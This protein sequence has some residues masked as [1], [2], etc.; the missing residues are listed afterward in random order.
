MCSVTAASEAAPNESSIVVIE[1]KNAD[2]VFEIKRYLPVSPAA[3]VSVVFD[4]GESTAWAFIDQNENFIADPDERQSPAVEVDSAKLSQQCSLHLTI[5]ANQNFP[6]RQANLT[7]IPATLP[8]ARKNLGTVADLNEARFAKEW[9]KVGLWNPVK[10]LSEVGGGLFLLRPYEPGQVPVIFVHG[11]FGAPVEFKK[12]AAEFDSPQYAPMVFYYPSGLPLEFLADFLERSIAELSLRSGFTRYAVVAH[13]MGGIVSKRALLLARE[14][15]EP[16]QPYVFV[17]LSTPWGG[18]SSAE[19][20][21]EHSPV[22]APCWR[23]MV[24]QSEILTKVQ[25]PLDCPHWLLF[26]FRGKPSIT[27]EQ[28]DT[29]VS[30]R[31][32]LE[33]HLQESAEV[34]RGFDETHTGILESDAAIALVKEAIKAP[35]K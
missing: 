2:G 21:V 5:P 7:T 4:A 14:R 9:G 23:D 34:I 16:A 33:P 15:K 26:S 17:S 8:L 29:S 30:I 25:L 19:L 24:P 32:E 27:G 13:S 12:L 28:N 6:K 31:S 10:F 20:G 3:P 35:M 11:L 1:Q 22:V 18:H